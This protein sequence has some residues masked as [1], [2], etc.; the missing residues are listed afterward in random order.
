MTGP[1]VGHDIFELLLVEALLLAVDMGYATVF[2][3]ARPSRKFLPLLDELGFEPYGAPQWGVYP[4]AAES[5]A[6]VQSIVV[7]THRRRP[8]WAHRK[9][10]VL[11][12][13]EDAGYTI[14][15]Y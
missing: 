15:S 3:G 11:A 5:G 6:P 13:L 7:S 10:Q 12:R 9:Q 14:G 4:D 2:G 1:D 8:A